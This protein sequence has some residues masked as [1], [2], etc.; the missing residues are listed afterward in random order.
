MKLISD[1]V[2]DVRFQQK[3]ERGGKVRGTACLS[4]EE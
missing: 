3:Q 4:R 2:S 1:R